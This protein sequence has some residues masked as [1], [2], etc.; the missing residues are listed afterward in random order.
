MADELDK[1]VLAQLREIHATLA[2]HTARFDQFDE[3][4]DQLE[5]RL[6]KVEEGTG[7]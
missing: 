2:D 5:R 7:R 6:A 1:L 4:F 3:R